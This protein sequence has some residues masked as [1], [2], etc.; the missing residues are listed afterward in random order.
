MTQREK[1]IELLS[2]KIYPR[3]GADPAEVV[4]DYL[5]DNGVTVQEHGRW[6]K[7]LRNH[8]GTSDYE[9]SACL[10]I[11]MDVPDDDE[12]ELNRYCSFCGARMDGDE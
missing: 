8:D 10:G 7:I 3:V 12:H 1:L 2:K 6:R 11:I 9:C 5:I 4:A